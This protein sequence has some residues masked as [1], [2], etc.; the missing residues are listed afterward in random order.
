M[1]WLVSASV[2]MAFCGV[3]GCSYVIGQGWPALELWAEILLTIV[4]TP[5]AGI[6]LLLFDKALAAICQT[7][8]AQKGLANEAVRE[9]VADGE[10]REAA[11]EGSKRHI[12]SKPQAP[13]ST[14]EKSDN[15]SSMQSCMADSSHE[16]ANKL[17]T[18]KSSLFDTLTPKWSV[19]SIAT[20][21]LIMCACWVIW[22]IANFPG[23]A[24]W[25]TYYQIFQVYPENH[26]I[27]IIPWSDVYNKTLTDAWLVDH[28]PV[29]VTMIYGAFGWVSDQL[30]GSWMAGVAVF[31]ALQ[32]VL[33]C[34]VFTSA[35]AYL[36]SRGCPLGVCLASY[37]FFAL[38]PFVPTW[39]MCMVKDS[40]FAVVFIPYMMMLI[41]T[42]ITQG[43]WLKKRSHCAWMVL[44]AVLLCLI[45]KQ[46]IFVVVA[47][48]VAGFFAFRIKRQGK[49]RETQGQEG[50]GLNQEEG[51]ESESQE[52]ERDD[53]GIQEA[54]SQHDC[55]AREVTQHD[56]ETREVSQCNQ[57]SQR[58]RQS[59]TSNISRISRMQITFILQLVIS[60][61]LIC[62]VLPYILFPI[63]NIEKGGMQET[64]GPA[65][66]QTA[67]VLVD[68]PDDVTDQERD[69]IAAVLDIDKITE[70]YSFDFEDAV[71]YRFNLNATSEDILRYLKVYLTQGLRH[72][73][74]YFG[75]WMS[76]AG[77]YV[78][79]C[80][81]V[82]IR[83]TTVDTKMGDEQRYMLWNP[84]GLDW[85]R[86]G[87]DN[88]YKAIAS[89]P[90]IDAPLLLV[91]YT[92]WLPLALMFVCARRRVSQKSA[93]R[94]G[95]ESQTR[96]K[97]D[98]TEGY[99]FA[100]HEDASHVAAS[101]KEKHRNSNQKWHEH[102][103]SS[104]RSE[105]SNDPVS[106]GTIHWMLVFIPVLVLCVFCYIAPVYDA[107][108]AIPVFDAAPLLFGFVCSRLACSSRGTAE[109][110]G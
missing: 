45:K 50:E 17:P 72:P 62:V 22:Y 84:D 95:I 63:L 9:T 52:E 92:F 100:A 24:Y 77:F 68:Y 61:A 73:D 6:V 88:G 46:A 4:F 32:G 2:L 37:L 13:V 107:R 74:S 101:K 27:S 69:A 26:P 11:G 109:I 91:A 87:L 48:S 1:V 57:G 105:G 86:E 28:H 71:K 58:A 33:S 98:N 67:R 90:V 102:R 56:C 43:I 20:F 35:C 103:N 60:L 44:L 94:Y 40:M 29:L 21:T 16:S 31:C 12:S 104:Q 49:R 70:D 99:G 108:Y 38:I 51:H 65:C 30:T 23:G 79:P 34:V 42:V 7:S 53:Q 85:L 78:A 96:I 55:G 15:A 36:R 39:A 25:D 81:Y 47:T 19:R 59:G 83:M 10:V 110:Q 41:E 3:F 8:A 18:N 75:A 93:V 5:V 89:T 54:I 82:N 106:V 97:S 14:R 64:L 80:A 76:L 66:Q